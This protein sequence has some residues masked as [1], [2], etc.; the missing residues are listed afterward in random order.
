MSFFGQSNPMARQ[1]GLANAL[2]G[3][4]A[5]LGAQAMT[6]G[7]VNSFQHAAPSQEWGALNPNYTRAGFFA[8]SPDIQQRAVSHRNP[9]FGYLPSQQGQELRGGTEAD[10]AQYRDWMQRYEASKNKGGFGVIKQG[11]TDM[12]K[13]VPKGPLVGL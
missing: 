6:S 4:G 8:N 13:L 3:R 12:A 7:G 9:L 11:L 2:R 10:M 1:M 5:P